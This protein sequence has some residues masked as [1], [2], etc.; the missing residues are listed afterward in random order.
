MF[1]SFM[2]MLSEGP[3]TSFNGSPTVSPITAAACVGVPFIQNFLSTYF[4]A[5]SH[6]P[7]PNVKKGDRLVDVG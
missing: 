1:V 2:N 7:P 3:A 4:L 6:M 5:L